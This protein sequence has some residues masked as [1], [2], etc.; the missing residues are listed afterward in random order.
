MRVMV[1]RA[2]AKTARLTPKP[3]YWPPIATPSN[4][5]MLGAAHTMGTCP[6]HAMCLAVIA[7][8]VN[9]ALTMFAASTTSLAAIVPCA[10][11]VSVVMMSTRRSLHASY[12]ANGPGCGY[13]A[14]KGPKPD[15]I[16]GCFRGPV[17]VPNRT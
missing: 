3:A 12:G 2:V 8:T 4:V 11:A 5:T 6:K 17:M 1:Y 16:L 9:A 14:Y 15:R 10:L 13:R 7:G